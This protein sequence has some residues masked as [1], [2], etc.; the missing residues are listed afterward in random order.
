MVE[1]NSY[2]KVLWIDNYGVFV[3]LSRE[4]NLFKSVLFK[5]YNKNIKSK[6]IPGSL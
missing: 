3:L 5:W 2:V 6:G 4:L 1:K